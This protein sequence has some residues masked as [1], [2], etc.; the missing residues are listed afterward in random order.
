MV[1]EGRAIEDDA[2]DPAKSPLT[3]AG[4]APASPRRASSRV[5]FSA[6]ALALAKIGRLPTTFETGP[7]RN[8]LAVV[9]ITT[10][11]I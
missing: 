1:G 10:T 7:I 9:V 6:A 8:R 11:S 4:P 5:M 3:G 2:A